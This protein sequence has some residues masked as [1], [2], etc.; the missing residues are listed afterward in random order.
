M[1]TQIKSQKFIRN[2][3][4][5][6]GLLLASCS[7]TDSPAPTIPPVIIPVTPTVNAYIPDGWK[8]L[9]SHN[10]TRF[11]ATSEAVGEKIYAGLGYND[12]NFNSVTKD[13]Y[14]YDV[15]SNKWTIK[16]NFP[17][18]E[19]ANAISFMINNKIY[20]GMGTNYNRSTLINVYNDFY[21]YDPAT[22]KWT[23]KADFPAEGRDQ[24][25]FFTIG[26]KGYMGTG[27]TNPSN[28]TS[29]RSDFWE[30][31]PATDKWAQKASLPKTSRCRAFGFGVGTK[32]YLGG[33]EN[34]S[35]SKLGDF[36]QYDP[37]KDSWISVADLPV[38]IARSR[39]FAFNANGY[40][41]GGLTGFDATDV[42]GVVY[43]YNVSANTWEKISDVGV[44]DDTAKGRFYQIA[45]VTKSKVYIGLGASGNSETLKNQKDF[46]E[47][48]PK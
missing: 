5:A 11:C 24:S 8:A 38:A 34:A 48:T 39:G 16:T 25:V 19:R 12:N 46:Y 43:K 13:W 33:G 40:I 21:E 41:S 30:Y 4:V 37:A 14:E 1:K 3:V 10:E 18:A 29:V 31:D 9:Q 36:Y 32:G 44:V 22:D 7:K 2:G 20:V 26:N 15:A 35:V 27:N 28:S 17:G 6:I 47:Y 42:A 45:A 23:K